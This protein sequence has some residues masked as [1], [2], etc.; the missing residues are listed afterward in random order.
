[1]DSDTLEIIDEVYGGADFEDDVNWSEISRWDESGSLMF[2][3]SCVCAEPPYS[4][5]VIDTQDNSEVF[6]E[7]LNLYANWIAGLQYAHPSPDWEYMWA[8][9]SAGQLSESDEREL[10]VRINRSTLEYDFYPIDEATDDLGD[11][12]ISPD[13][14]TFYLTVPRTGEIIVW[15]P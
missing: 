8:T 1:M 11:F 4:F 9:V 12:A 2:I 5:K 15:Q 10:M 3:P 14:T 13:G 7:A 6:T